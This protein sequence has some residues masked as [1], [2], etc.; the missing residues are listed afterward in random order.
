MFREK[1]L[2]LEN[3]KRK[4][5]FVL[6]IWFFPANAILSPLIQCHKAQ[7][8]DYSGFSASLMYFQLWFQLVSFRGQFSCLCKKLTIIL[9]C[10]D[11][12]KELERGKVPLCSHSLKELLRIPWPQLL[13]KMVASDWIALPLEDNRLLAM[14]SEYVIARLKSKTLEW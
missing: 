2:S 11:Q 9:S 10:A 14:S 12:D 7:N 1:P 5:S 6:R 4:S 8:C 3:E 13:P